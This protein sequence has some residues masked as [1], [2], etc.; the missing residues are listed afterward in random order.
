MS[1]FHIILPKGEDRID[2]AVRAAL[3]RGCAAACLVATAKSWQK[4]K[5]AETFPDGGRIAILRPDIT[6]SDFEGVLKGIPHEVT[7]LIWWHPPEGTTDSGDWNIDELRQ[8]FSRHK[9]IPRPVGLEVYPF[10]L[11]AP[12]Q[13]RWDAAVSQLFPGDA[14][15]PR[16]ESHFFD[17]L[18]EVAKLARV[19]FGCFGQL[20]KL[21]AAMF[22]VYMVLLEAEAAS[23]CSGSPIELSGE[24][25]RPFMD[26]PESLS[27]AGVSDS[28]MSLPWLD[29]IL[30][31]GTK[32]VQP[33]MQ[34]DTP[35]K[36]D[37]INTLKEARKLGTEA[38]AMGNEFSDDPAA[39]KLALP[40]GTLFTSNRIKG[41]FTLLEIEPN[42]AQ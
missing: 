10:S 42:P 7:P 29:E 35:D 41:L 31:L 18:D 2:P 37:L 20:K 16:P 9:C 36:Q 34:S 25:V 21:L 15:P 33:R 23:R 19:H 39:W 17:E 38:A 28:E 24:T 30:G 13:N 40:S 6:Q 1:L 4:W 12:N 22:P 8:S 14:I 11:G 32:P 5:I 26:L 3:G 27:D